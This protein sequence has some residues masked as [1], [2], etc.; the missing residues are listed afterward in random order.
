MNILRNLSPDLAVFSSCNS[1]MG[2]A[3]LIILKHVACHVNQHSPDSQKENMLSLL[4]GL[5]RGYC[6]ILLSQIR[7]QRVKFFCLKLCFAHARRGLQMC[8]WRDVIA[9]SSAPISPVWNLF[10]QN[11]HKTAGTGKQIFMVGRPEVLSQSL[12]RFRYRLSVVYQKSLNV[13]E[14]NCNVYWSKV[15]IQLTPKLLRYLLVQPSLY[16]WMVSTGEP[17]LYD[18]PKKSGRFGLKKGRSLLR[19]SFT[20]NA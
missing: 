3:K 14:Q 9:G 10:S 1:A 19:T 13:S 20:C 17:L 11:Q 18:H 7:D 15:W 12:P 6:C 2:G 4:N 8:P 5:G 16:E